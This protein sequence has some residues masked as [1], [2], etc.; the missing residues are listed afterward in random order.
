MQK[1]T[2]IENKQQKKPKSG[3]FKSSMKL[4]NPY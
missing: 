3:S 4:R 2:E 1:I